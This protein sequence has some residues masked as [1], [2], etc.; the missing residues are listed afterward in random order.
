VKI[1]SGYKTVAY[2]D[3]NFAGSSLT[4]TA[5]NSCLVS[6]SWNDII[7]SLRVQ[8]ASA[9]LASAKIETLELNLYP[10]PATNEIRL[11]T[12]FELN[13]GI[14]QVYDITGHPA[15]AFK[16]VSDRIDVSGLTAGIYTLVY[17]KNGRTIT[18]RFVKN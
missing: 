7:S 9:A 6:Q 16:V 10:N 12:N 2:A 13:G 1:N 17:T 3:D 8:T 14:I 18:K 11:H 5:N 4:I 15:R